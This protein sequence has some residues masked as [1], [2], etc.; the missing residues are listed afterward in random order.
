MRALQAALRL[1]HASGAAAAPGIAGRHAAGAAFARLLATGPEDHAAKHAGLKVEQGVHRREIP[2][3]GV[4]QGLKL[5]GV[6]TMPEGYQS[7]IPPESSGGPQGEAQRDLEERKQ[8][9]LRQHALDTGLGTGKAELAR[10]L[11]EHGV[12][13]K[14]GPEDARKLLDAL[15][16]WKEGSAPK[17]R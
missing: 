16:K 12:I 7:V 9:A 1:A 6:P 5:K 17:T 10:L 15:M 3:P 4:Q 13:C 8:R 14:G 11:A 2:D